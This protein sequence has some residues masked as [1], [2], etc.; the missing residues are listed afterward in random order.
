MAQKPRREAYTAPSALAHRVK[1]FD[2]VVETWLYRL[3]EYVS[4]RWPRLGR[5]L[6]G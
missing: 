6:A 5:W 1:R 3:Q 2:G 4:D